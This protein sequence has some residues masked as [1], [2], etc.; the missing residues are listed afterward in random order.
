MAT[1]Q[2]HVVRREVVE[3]VLAGN[4]SDGFALQTMLADLCRDQLTRAL[5]GTFEETIRSDE[6]WSIDR[7]VVDAGSF[8]VATLE[9]DFIGA[10]TEAVRRQIGDRAAGLGSS[11]RR[12]EPRRPG[13]AWPDAEGQDR[14]TTSS[15]SLE[16]RSEGELLRDAFLHFLATG[17]LPWWF[18]LPNGSSLEDAITAF[19]RT[20]GR[21]DQFGRALTDAIAPQVMRTRLVRQFS[22]Q[23]LG[24]LLESMSPEAMRTV[25]EVLAEAS[26]QGHRTEPSSRFSEQLWLAAFAQA[27]RGFPVTGEDVVADWLDRLSGAEREPEE[28]RIARIAERWL[29]PS[30]RAGRTGAATTERRQ[31]RSDQPPREERSE[32]AEPTP[33]TIAWGEGPPLLIDL[34]EGVFV[35]CAGL[36]LLHPFLPRLFEVLGIARSGQL[37]LPD[38]ALCVLHFLATGER[39]APEYALVLAKVLCNLPLDEPVGAPVGLSAE[40]ETEATALLAAVI[41]HWNALGG[42]SVD[43]LRGTFLVR[44]G[45]LSRRG[46]D[47]VLQVERESF[48]IL[49]AQLPWGIGAIRLPWMKKILWVEWTS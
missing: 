20:A 4:E 14:S 35:E 9:R 36:V 6:H 42:T 17:A 15:G 38:R 47:D 3:V 33:P 12:T 19:R 21:L 39:R 24:A 32:H 40:E 1:A 37:V 23:F 30:K 48:D 5:E 26:R 49:L 10:V 45:K 46:E 43:G 41:E 13:A 18:P 34:E 28:Q 8:S 11:L 27:A 22:W 7:L 29:A 16:R 2:R 44:A 31:T 25:Q